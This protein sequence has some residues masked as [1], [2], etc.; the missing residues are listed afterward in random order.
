MWIWNDKLDV[1]TLRAQL[2]DMAG[3]GALSPM[4]LP[5]PPEFRP[6]WMPTRMEPGYLTPEFFTLIRAAADD[7]QRLGLRLWLYDEG[8]WPSGNV[9]GRLVK[10]HPEFGRQSLQREERALKAGQEATVPGGC[11]AAYIVAPDGSRRRLTSGEK[12]RAGADG[13]RMLVFSVTRNGWHADL[14]NPLAVA[15]FIRMTHDGYREAAGSHFGRAVPAIFTDEP[16]MGSMPWTEGFAEAFRT[17]RGYDILDRLPSLYEGDSPSD[18]TTRIDYFDW[19]SERFAEAYF[20]QIQTWCRRH[21]ILSA[22]HLNGEDETLGAR[23]HGFGNAMRMLRRMDVP[24]VDAIWRQLWPGKR[25]HHFPKLASSVAHQEGLPWAIT[26]SFAVYGSGLTPA[27]M[28]WIVDY[29]FVRGINLLDMIGYPY[30]TAD[31]FTGG[32]RP[33]YHPLNPLWDALPG[34]HSYV[35]R[36]SYLLSLGRPDIRIAL[37]FPIRDVWAGGSQAEAVARTHDEAAQTLLE[38]Q[39]DF[40]LVDD[41]A[42]MRPGTAIRDGKLHV[43]PMAYD[44]VVITRQ[45]WLAPEARRRLEEFARSGGALIAV[46]MDADT[47]PAGA[48]IASPP[49]LA[50]RLAPTI[51]TDKPAPSL[52]VSVRRSE[53]EAIY[54][55]TNEGEGA[56]DVEAIFPE[57]GPV[58]ELDAET[59]T[60]RRVASSRIATSGM[61]VRLRFPFAGSR[62][63]LFGTRTRPSAAP[64]S[65]G[66]EL[67]RLTS[68]WRCRPVASYVITE[69]D[70]EKREPAASTEPIGVALGD[71][72]AAL[73]KDFSGEAVYES[74]F[75]CTPVAAADARWL[76]L[77]DVRYAC[78]IELNE[79]DLGWRLWPEWRVP[80]AGLLRAGVNTLRVKVVN[81]LA[82]QY[83]H[84]R[85]YERWTP[86][87]LGPYHP[88][89]LTFEPDSLPS[90]L[91]GPVRILSCQP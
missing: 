13:A 88:R 89:A 30:S 42:L 15:E 60:V 34:F 26:E 57:T 79:R 74:R 31:W 16:N 19:W 78:R 22:G 68:G 75:D 84:N 36:L 91:F 77:G 64:S 8:G 50:D 27:Q 24:G 67:L 71:W 90:G 33:N 32:E 2:A 45:R 86:A 76:D 3:H 20:G 48:V 72:G 21:G 39:C 28:K 62:I 12:V 73:G 87:Q 23:M 53:R 69:R 41:E 5:E 81:T 85:A 29:Q 70:I 46:G 55:L 25:N 17:D 66:A 59:G 10:S 9:C 61:R 58:C 56:L 83:V 38:R 14:L 4:P 54:F 51:R 37:V 49:D 80:I 63:L 44:A 65:A 18:A 1:H 82:N 47:L 7:A 11:L 52:R 35:A 43:G 6:T 40:D